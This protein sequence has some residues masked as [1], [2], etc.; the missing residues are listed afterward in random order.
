[1]LK[2]K[3]SILL[4]ILLVSKVFATDVVKIEVTKSYFGK[5]RINIIHDLEKS[6]PI[7]FD[8]DKS[9][10]KNDMFPGKSYKEAPLEK[11]LNDLMKNTGLYYKIIDETIVIR[12][13]GAEIK[14]KAKVYERKTN[15]TLIGKVK[16]KVTGETLPFA[17]LLIEGTNNGTITNA[18]GHFTLF[19][20]PSDTSVIAVHY[21]GFDVRHVY[22]T[23]KKASQELIIELFPSTTEIEEVVVTAE[24]EDLMRISESIS[25]VSLNPLKIKDLPSIGDKDLFRTFQLMPGISASNESSSG[26]YV[27]GGTPDQNLILYDGFTVYHV[28]HLFG[29]F[30]A[31]NADAI[32]DVKLSKGG[33]ESKYGGRISS[34]MEIIGKDGN[35]NKTSYGAGIGFLSYNGYVEFPI[36]DKITFIAVGRKSFQSFLYDQFFDM[37]NDAESSASAPVPAGAR[38]NKTTTFNVEPS[39]YFYDLNSKLTYKPNNL[40]TISLSFYNGQDDLDN[41][42]ELNLSRGG[43]NLSG[44]TTDLTKWGNWGSSLKWSSKWN[45]NLYTNTLL[46]YSR[47]YS[48][49]DMNSERTSTNSN[50]GSTNIMSFGTN[51]ENILQDYSAKYD[52][53]YKLSNKNKIEA[54]LQYNFFNIDY[55]HTRSD[56]IVIQD[57]HNKKSQAAFYIQDNVKLFDKLLLIPGL[58]TSYFEGTN[59]IYLE[60]RLSASYSLSKHI[61]LNTAWGKYN[62]FTNRIIRDDIESGSRDFWVLSDGETI[63]VGSSTHYIIG[64][65][66]ENLRYLF[67]V[68]LFYKDMSG[69]TEYSLNYIPSFRDLEYDEFYYQGTGIA[70]GMELLAQKKF[71]KLSGWLGYTLSRV[72]YQFDLYGEDP[73]PASH[74]ATHEFTAVTTYKWKKFTFSGTWIYAT[75]KPYTAPSGSYE[76][77][78]PDGNTQYLLSIGDKNTLRLPDYHRLDL[79]VNY[80]FGLGDFGGGVL[81]FSLFNAYNRENIWYKEYEFLDGELIETNVNYLGITPN[82]SISI[83]LK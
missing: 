5:T 40:N 43:L 50:S 69:L 64:A 3:I 73:F 29:M 17:Q 48:I 32:K 42:R 22:L 71:G 67:S 82:L 70:Q 65:N 79:S 36:K 34:V 60:P 80:K 57:Q 55:D 4:L 26:L 76:I 18:D 81:G 61:K 62:Q 72:D 8:Y 78:L 47:Y 51:E 13:I 20:I 53:E 58:R 6:F 23:P 66:Y 24:R 10:F 38:G 68:E 30:S 37:F 1:M 56:T 7:Y 75:G 83:N 54:G 12:P 45:N 21:V 33:F 9:Y 27:R 39:S 2:T 44:G 77:T 35:E 11:V 15:F 25:R 31:F 74:D 41:S 49:R 14:F 59:K 28:D 19:N 46:S 16:D 63:P 52:I